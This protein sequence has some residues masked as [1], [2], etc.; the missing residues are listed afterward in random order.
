MEVKVVHNP[1]S[2][3][4]TASGM[5]F[6]IQLEMRGCRG[7]GRLGTDGCTSSNNLDIVVEAMKFGLLLGKSWRKDPEAM[8][9]GEMVR[10]AT[11]NGA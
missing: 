8:P 3:H 7:S 1:L 10:M 11:A 9:A 5:E 4:E 6:K 2:K